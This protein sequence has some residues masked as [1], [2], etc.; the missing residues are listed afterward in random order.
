VSSEC[1][2]R[3]VEN[4]TDSWSLR[5]NQAFNP[6]HC[7]QLCDAAERRR[8]ISRFLCGPDR[9]IRADYSVFQLSAVICSQDHVKMWSEKAL[10]GK[11][12]PEIRI[13]ARSYWPIRREASRSLKS[14]ARKFE[15][16]GS[17]YDFSY[18]RA[19]ATCTANR[20]CCCNAE[21]CD[22]RWVGARER[23]IKFEASFEKKR[24]FSEINLET[25]I[26]IVALWRWQ[27]ICSAFVI[28]IV[29]DAFFIH[30]KYTYLIDKSFILRKLV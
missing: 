17:A 1:D 2:G 16:S 14:T 9:L 30:P 13:K 29:I 15:A 5:I 6:R 4:C 28:V 3:S 24:E 22:R 19:S 10:F 27:N 23:I 25:A 26:R 11:S 12:R 18:F 7:R 8:L 21:S 20:H